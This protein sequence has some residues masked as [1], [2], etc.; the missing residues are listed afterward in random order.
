MRA[1]V[2][3]LAECKASSR[4]GPARGE[5]VRAARS[6]EAS[7]IAPLALGVLAACSLAGCVQFVAF[8][9]PV[10][11]HA[12]YTGPADQRAETVCDD[13]V[14][15]GGSALCS[16]SCEI[17]DGETTCGDRVTVEGS[18]ARV[19]VDGLR[20][21]EITMT[22]C[23][24]E[25]RFFSLD[26][27]GTADITIEGRVLTIGAAEGDTLLRQ[28]E[29]LPEEECVERTIVLQSGR[30]AVLDSGRRVC[31]SELPSLE[32]DWRIEMVR[33]ARAGAR[34]LE[35]CFREPR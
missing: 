34:T 4:R 2:S 28:P 26:G 24:T 15:I 14:E 17:E 3:S 12:D 10:I 23:A 33:T 8:E 5:A 11:G 20:E 22:V 18:N 1:A 6:G 31:S 27:S 21:V 7:R 19:R 32:E 30:L 29:N 35:L 13:D 9:Q 16:E 25:G